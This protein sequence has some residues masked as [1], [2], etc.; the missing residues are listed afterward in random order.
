MIKK[1][2]SD[3]YHKLL[4]SL[5]VMVFV[6]MALLVWH[7]LNTRS[8]VADTIA[9]ELYATADGYAEELREQIETMTEMAVPVAKYLETKDFDDEQ[10]WDEV[11]TICTIL[12]KNTKADGNRLSG[13]SSAYMGRRI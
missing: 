13:R 5:F 6:V 7:F 10:F 1:K 8:M 11:A 2:N 12:Q 4:T 3:D 9:G